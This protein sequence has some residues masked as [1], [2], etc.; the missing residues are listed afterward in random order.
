MGLREISLREI[1]KIN[2]FGRPPTQPICM[3]KI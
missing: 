1:N 3:G 2:H